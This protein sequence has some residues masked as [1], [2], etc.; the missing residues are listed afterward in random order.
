MNKAGR[1]KDTLRKI[2]LISVAV[3]VLGGLGWAVRIRVTGGWIQI[4]DS[5]NLQAGPGSDLISSYQSLVDAVNIDITGA[6][7][8]IWQVN[9][10]R[11]D[12]NWPPAFTLEARRT[13]SHPNVYGGTAY[14]QV[15]TSDQLFFY[16]DIRANNTRNIKIQYRLS[17][18]SVQ[19]PPGTYATVVYYTVTVI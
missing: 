18:V 15:T 7:N 16:T 4:I 13:S 2:V 9:I 14:Q 5:N 10:R 1:K 19:I 8:D 17:G 3:A 11:V 6:G 12:T